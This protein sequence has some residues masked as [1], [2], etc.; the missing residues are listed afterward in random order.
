MFQCTRRRDKRLQ[1]LKIYPVKRRR[2]RSYSL[3][4]NR[5]HGGEL[6]SWMMCKLSREISHNPRGS[7]TGVAS[8][9]PLQK[10]G[11]QFSFPT[12]SNLFFF[13]FRSV[14]VYLFICFLCV[15]LFHRDRRGSCIF[16][17]IRCAQANVYYSLRGICLPIP[18]TGVLMC[19]CVCTRKKVHIMPVQFTEP[20]GYGYGK[21]VE[22][23]K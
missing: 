1:P 8:S 9:R 19:V 21:G 6:W 22:G 15:H 13:P 3:V 20:Y 17:I 5:V 16:F 12:L 10:L 7:E 4:Q 14:R 23:F 2:L 18:Y 11:F